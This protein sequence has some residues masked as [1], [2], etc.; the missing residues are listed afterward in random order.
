MSAAG[1]YLVVVVVVAEGLTSGSRRPSLLAVVVFL[2]QF[3]R[4]GYQHL[5]FS[6]EESSV[7]IQLVSQMRFLAL[8]KQHATRE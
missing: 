5:L 2:A 1:V 7:L 3:C 4:C 8:R 6:L